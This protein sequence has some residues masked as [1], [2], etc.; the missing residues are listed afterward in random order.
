MSLRMSYFFY[1]SSVK[2]FTVFFEFNKLKVLDLLKNDHLSL[3]N[4]IM[5]RRGFFEKRTLILHRFSKLISDDYTKKSSIKSI[6]LLKQ[7]CQNVR[8]Y[9]LI[10]H[11]TGW[12][13]P[14]SRQKINFLIKKYF[15][16]KNK[17]SIPYNIFDSDFGQ[18]QD[19][20]TDSTK[21]LSITV[22]HSYVL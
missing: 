4:P 11:C 1:D 15:F 14:S 17:K 5:A 2:E 9:L 3:F 20:N 12:F 7:N 13:Y 18:F 10:L 21:I 22:C 6:L 8:F 16:T 19:S